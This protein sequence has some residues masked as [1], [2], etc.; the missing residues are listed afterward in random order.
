[1]ARKISKINTQ[2]GS[3]EDYF[4]FEGVPF[5]AKDF[6]RVQTDIFQKVERTL[7][8]M[9]EDLQGMEPEEKNLLMNVM[10]VPAWRNLRECLGASLQSIDNLGELEKYIYECATIFYKELDHPYWSTTQFQY[11]LHLQPHHPEYWAGYAI[12]LVEMQDRGVWEEFM[13]EEKAAI[14]FKRSARLC[15]AHLLRKTEYAEK[16][17]E[18]K[19]L[20]HAQRYYENANTLDPEP[21]AE[22][23]IHL[24]R[25]MKKEKKFRNLND[26]EKENA[27]LEDMK[28]EIRAVLEIQLQ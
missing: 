16:I 2:E 28:K 7:I 15:L 19:L 11:L 13:L 27:E 1:M 20:E 9:E 4:G 26:L 25:K 21:E 14:A 23:G 10:K 12:C 6:I 24:A 3:S 22:Q 5:D 17:S 18:K 8:S